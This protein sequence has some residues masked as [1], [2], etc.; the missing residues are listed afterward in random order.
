MPRPTE[1]LAQKKALAKKL[2]SQGK[3]F[4]EIQKKMKEEFH[5]EISTRYLGDL[6]KPRG[7]HKKS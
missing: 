3:T 4:K 7:K 2:R 6:P 5:S 1:N